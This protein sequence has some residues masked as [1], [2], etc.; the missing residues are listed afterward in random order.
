MNLKNVSY[1][2]N[3]KSNFMIESLLLRTMSI[4]PRRDRF[5]QRCTQ[6][7]DVNLLIKDQREE[8]TILTTQ[9]TSQQNVLKKIAINLSTDSYT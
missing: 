9:S 7:D 3:G 5:K 1:Q 2:S 8:L 6:I 4:S